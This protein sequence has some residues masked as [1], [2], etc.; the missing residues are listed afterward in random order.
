M[1]AGAF[2]ELSGPVAGG[3]TDWLHHQTELLSTWQQKL[4]AAPKHGDESSH[5]VVLCI[6]E[7]GQMLHIKGLDGRTL[8]QQVRAA[9]SD[10][11]ITLVLADTSSKITNFLAESKVTPSTRTAF[12]EFPAPW[13]AFNTLDFL[14]EAEA[15]ADLDPA[16][17]V[18]VPD[19]FHAATAF[20]LGRHLW[21]W[22][23]E[24]HRDA[25]ELIRFAKVKLLCDNKF[26]PLEPSHSIAIVSARTTLQ[27]TPSISSDL[28]KRHMA[29]CIG[30]TTDREVVYG[31]YLS[32]PV[33]AEAAAQLMYPRGS[34]DPLPSILQ[35]THEYLSLG[36][37]SNVGKTGEFAFQLIAC[38]AKDRVVANDRARAGHR[39][40]GLYTQEVSF[41]SFLR[42]LCSIENP[43]QLGSD[44]ISCAFD[45][46]IIEG[47]D[48]GSAT[49]SFTHFVHTSL[50]LLEQESLKQLYM[51]AAAVVLQ[52][53][54]PGSDLAIPIR[55]ASGTFAAM[56][57]QVKN[58]GKNTSPS[59]DLESLAQNT[60]IGRLEYQQ[61]ISDELAQQYFGLVFQVGSYDRNTNK[62]SDFFAKCVS[63]VAAQLDRTTLTRMMISHRTTFRTVKRKK[64]TCGADTVIETSIAIPPY[65]CLVVPYQTQLTFLS[66][67]AREWIRRICNSTFVAPALLRTFDSE[68]SG[69]TQQFQSLFSILRPWLVRGI[70]NDQIS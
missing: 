33:L 18:R 62:E 24:Q 37:N 11:K 25:W 58:Y 69:R 47:P 68:L 45:T 20:R 5:R 39:S 35:R 50:S 61:E 15:D 56:L 13:I 64:R 14:S 59:S 46:L 26:N 23:Y 12:A 8:F 19:T 49:V 29:T 3:V 10:A 63:L 16:I 6:D 41:E 2:W 7:A 66:S 42:E 32:E 21:S 44:S 1:E 48:F 31:R 28:I 60:S 54:A 4:N 52:D 57:V 51:R 67:P 34:P 27:L 55:F 30:I 70:T 38:L 36:G 65:R 22:Y 40:N 43:F 17:T 9:A 53:N